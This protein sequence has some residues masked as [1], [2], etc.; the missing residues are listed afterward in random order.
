M[1]QKE[2]S[3][4]LRILPSETPVWKL[5][6]YS[7]D[8]MTKKTKIT[9]VRQYSFWGTINQLTIKRYCLQRNTVGTGVILD[10]LLVRILSTEQSLIN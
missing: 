6:P 10:F 1:R 9:P 2:T 5:T 4:I 3:S 7:N 8:D